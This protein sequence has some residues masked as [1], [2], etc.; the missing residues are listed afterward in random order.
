VADPLL[1]AQHFL[2]LA[3][4]VPLYEATL[5]GDDER[6]TPAELER[7]ADEGVRVFL[8]A[9]SRQR[10]KRSRRRPGGVRARFVAG[11]LEVAETAEVLLQSRRPRMPVSSRRSRRR[12]KSS[13]S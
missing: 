10:P 12:A 11:S 13:R 5:T 7:F 6:F 1:A 4:S 9:Y 8:A 3:V 2:W